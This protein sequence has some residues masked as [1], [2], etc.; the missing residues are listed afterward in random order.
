MI[1]N[2]YAAIFKKLKYIF[3]NDTRTSQYQ[4]YG[5]EYHK[6]KTLPAVLIFPDSKVWKEDP[7]TQSYRKAGLPKQVIYKYNLWIYISLTEIEDSYFN[8]E[9][10]P[11]AGVTQVLTAIEQVL[12]DNKTGNDIVDDTIQLWTNIEYE[13]VEISQRPGKLMSGRLS[14]NFI[15]KEIS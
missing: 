5:A 1:F 7:N 3:E 2:K 12:L 9:D 11:K 14:V 15:T 13:N 4:Y 8:E 10:G 6:K